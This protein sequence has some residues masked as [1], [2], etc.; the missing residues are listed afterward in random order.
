VG[1]C[2]QPLPKQRAADL[3]HQLVIVLKPELK[4][5]LHGPHG[6]VPISQFE[7]GLTQAGQAILVVGIEG[8]SLLEAAPS[9]R[10]LLA[11]EMGVG[12]ADMKFD[13]VGVEGNPLFE[14]DQ[15]FIV[16]AFVIEVMGSFIEV[17]GA[18][19]CFRHR[20]DLRRQV[21]YDKL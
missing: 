3:E 15:R 7:Q 2:H 12:G 13:C 14:D 16:E 9:P 6:P 1:W 20:Q 5:A 18:E 21:G 11:G 4:D 10:E 8:Q 17:V 19:K